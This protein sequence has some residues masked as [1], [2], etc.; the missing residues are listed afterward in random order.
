MPDDQAKEVSQAGKMSFIERVGKAARSRASAIGLAVGL[1][2]GVV[3]GQQP[4]PQ[5]QGVDH[6]PGISKTDL[7]N[8]TNPPKETLRRP[9]QNFLWFYSLA[10]DAQRRWA[11]SLVGSEIAIIVDTPYLRLHDKLIASD[12]VQLDLNLS[13]T[14]PNATSDGHPVEMRVTKEQYEELKSK[15]GVMKDPE[16]MAEK[17]FPGD[18]RVPPGTVFNFKVEVLPRGDNPKE[19]YSQLVLQNYAPLQEVAR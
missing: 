17:S 13:E 19:Q 6:G 5:P 4:S 9:N 14:P 2:G 12:H 8:W 10:G 15:F 1:A 11:D 16:A 3:A 18:V 7:A